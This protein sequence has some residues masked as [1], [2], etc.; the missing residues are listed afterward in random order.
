MA[1][2]VHRPAP[3]PQ[4]PRAVRQDRRGLADP[5]VHPGPGPGDGRAAG[6]PLAR[7]R[8]ARLLRR[9]PL[10]PAQE[11]RRAPRHG[12]GRGRARRGLHPVSPVLLQHHRLEPER[13]LAR[14]RAHGAAGCV[15]VEHHRPLAGARRVHRVD[16]RD[17][18]G[19]AGAVRSRRSRPGAD[20]VQ[21][22]L[23][24]ARRDRPGRRL[25][26]GD[27]RQR[28]G[29]GGAARPRPT[30]TSWPSSP[31]SAR[32]GGWGPTPSR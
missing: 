29:G 9:L 3:R 8:A 31:R 24:A 17:G 30:R 23:P 16:D 27:R 21:R 1:R 22:P 12:G 13:A 5:P 19:G 10:R 2:A 20:P 32:S 11:R 18:P 25:S 7:D 28:A 26:A 14:R 6:P 15:R 4:G